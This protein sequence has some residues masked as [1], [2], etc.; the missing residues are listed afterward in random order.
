MFVASPELIAQKVRINPIMIVTGSGDL[1]RSLRYRGRHTL[2]AVLGLL[3][4]QRAAR[5]FVYSHG[6]AG[7]MLWIDVQT[8]A[9]CRLQ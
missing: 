5:A 2:R 4:S 9:F 6:S 7:R 8:G 3:G 1:A